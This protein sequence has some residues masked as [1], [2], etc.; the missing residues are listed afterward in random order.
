MTTGQNPL[1]RYRILDF[2]AFFAGPNATKMLA[3]FGADVIK[4]EPLDGDPFRPLG[5]QFR[6]SNRGKRSIAVD[7]KTPEGQEIVQK[8]LKTA[9]IITHNMRPGV[10][11]RLGIG[12][13]QVKQINPNVVYLHAPGWGSNGPKAHL[14]SFAPLFSGYVGLQWEAAGKG[15]A[16]VQTIGNEDQFNSNLGA[17]A[18]LMGIL[19]A[20]K[21]GESQLVEGPQLTAAIFTT[22][23]VILKPDN[24]TLFSFEIDSEQMGY[25]PLNR[26]YR[27]AD[28]WVT[29]VVVDER[30][31]RALTKV[32]GL[33]T[34]G[35]DPRFQDEAGREQHAEA[36]ESAIG[37]LLA[38]LNS[39]EAIKHLRDAGVPCEH[40]REE[41]MNPTYFWLEENEQVGRIAEY[42]DPKAG[43]IRDVGHTVRLSETPGAILRPP[44]LLG[45]HT[46]EILGELGYSEEQIA[47][48]KE[49]GVVRMAS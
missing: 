26:M 3:D 16:P 1:K 5:V 35:T 27:T 21:T 8:L 46:A 12:Y 29:I 38:G 20:A 39:E 33:E 18:M 11:E 48:V 25:G 23:E 32:Q 22:S 4:V 49:K 41:S 40:S 24:S 37:Q 47:A 28:G 44:P 2:G 42:E 34:L 14:Q 31:W 7:L 43:L 19:R 36:L 17:S 10:A 9:Q 6:A 13:D 15:N 45:Q 30:S